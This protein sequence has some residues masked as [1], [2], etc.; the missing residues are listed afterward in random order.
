MSEPVH[1]PGLWS[2]SGPGVLAR[3]G[4]LVVLSSVAESGLTDRLLDVLAEAADAGRDGGQFASAVETALEHDRSWGGAPGQPAAPSVVAF[5][6]VRGGLA[7]I[8]A[9]T[10]WAELATGAGLEH[11]AAGQPSMLLRCVLG[12][13]VS[14]VHAGLGAGRPER[15][16]TDRF[17]R[18]DGGTTRAGSLSYYAGQPAAA[19]PPPAGPGAA[20]PAPR[21]AS[22]GPP[23]SGGPPAGPAAPAPASAARPAA[24]APAAPRSA[25]PAAANPP[26]GPAPAAPPSARPAAAKPPAAP[27]AAAPGPAGAPA[28]AGPAAA[29]AFDAVLLTDGPPAGQRPP[30]PM[31]GPRPGGSGDPVPD[32]VS[33]MGV[34]CKNGHFD[35]PDARFCAVCGIS[36]NQQTLVPRLGP[37]PPLGVLVLDDGGILQLDADYVIGREPWLDPSVAAGQARPLPVADESGTVSRV[38]AQIRLADWQVL[39]TDLGSANGTRIGLPDET[40]LRPLAPQVPA[41]L[42]PGSRVELG[43]C[44]FRYESHRGR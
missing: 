7:V 35:D 34:Y 11:L 22:A 18:L 27:P 20:G 5:G 37:R 43:R 40:A 4:D 6:P 10:A 8:V 19:G 2:A 33:I 1:Q 12:C 3:Q 31:P 29:R 38:H 30:L 26:P 28:Q 39:V 9:G 14:A 42:R 24:P 32:G 17:S 13:P 16:R 23:A 44:A 36:M 25:G 21:A 41:A 15:G